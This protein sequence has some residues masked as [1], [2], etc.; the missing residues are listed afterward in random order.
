[1]GAIVYLAYSMYGTGGIDIAKSSNGTITGGITSTSTPEKIYNE[2]YSQS[3]TNNPYGVYDLRGGSYE[4]VASYVNYE[5]NSFDLLTY[6]GTNEGD[7]YGSALERSTS[8]RYKTVYVASGTSQGNSY[9]LAASKKG[10]AIYET[11]TSY[12]GRTSWNNGTGNGVNSIFPTDIYPFFYY[13]GGCTNDGT[14]M[15]FFDKFT[16]DG[17]W[18]RA[19]RVILCP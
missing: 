13:G 1:M 18:D 11:S 4:R 15:F 9:E 3:T 17:E 19:F 5:N 6:G 2:N 8:T 14:G 12:Q 7:L 10:D 16:G